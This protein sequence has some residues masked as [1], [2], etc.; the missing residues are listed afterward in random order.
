MASDGR[1]GSSPTPGTVKLDNPLIH[2]CFGGFSFYG[3]GLL[4]FF[5]GSNWKFCRFLS[6]LRLDTNQSSNIGLC[7]ESIHEQVYFVV[8]YFIFVDQKFVF[9]LDLW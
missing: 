8:E 1:V 2:V 9:E 7:W 5:H 3:G 4:F 6:R